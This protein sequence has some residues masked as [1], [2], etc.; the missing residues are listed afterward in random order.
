[1]NLERQTMF[2]HYYNGMYINGSISKP[3]CYVTDDLGI[4]VGRMFKSYRAAQIAITKARKS[5][6]PAS[7]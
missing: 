4:F 7:R 3:C 2:T 6:V 5:G 1:M